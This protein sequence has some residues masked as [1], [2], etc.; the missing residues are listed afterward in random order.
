M[1]PLSNLIDDIYEVIM[2]DPKGC[3]RS[4]YGGNGYDLEAC[5]QGIENIREEYDLKNL[6]V[7]GHS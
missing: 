4:N 3:G 7:I 1:E 6:V 5:L 2:F